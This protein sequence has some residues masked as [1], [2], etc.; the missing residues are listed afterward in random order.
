MEVHV[1]IRLLS[2]LGAIVVA[3]CA[4]GEPAGD[5]G[6]AQTGF[7]LRYRLE[8]GKPVVHIIEAN[9]VVTG[10]EDGTQEKSTEVLRAEMT[11]TYVGDDA[12][13]VEIKNVDMGGDNPTTRVLKE[14]PEW[15]D[16]L[17]DSLGDF[18]LSKATYRMTSRGFVS[19]F[20]SSGTS[21]LPGYAGAFGVGANSVI[22]P[23]KRV[24]PGESWTASLLLGGPAPEERV[25][26]GIELNDLL[27]IKDKPV[28]MTFTLV[29]EETHG[30]K[31]MLHLTAMAMGSGMFMKEPMHIWLEPETGSIIQVNLVTLIESNNAHGTTTVKIVRSDFAGG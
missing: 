13:E 7:L 15:E 16:A 27:E 29:G 9:T 23:E 31:R 20:K 25:M 4:G 12:Y 6:N 3:G 21:L 2:L 14:N 11:T 22:F 5:V 19:E 18:Y 10:Y 28:E 26:H 30:G 8:E 24:K 17:G 1:R